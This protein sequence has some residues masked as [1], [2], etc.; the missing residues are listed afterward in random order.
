MYLIDTNVISEARKGK[1]ANP[2]VVAFFQQCLAQEHRIYLSV[3]TVGELRRGVDSQHPCRVIVAM[4]HKRSAWK[5][6]C[7]KSSRGIG[8]SSCHSIWTLPRSGVAC[9]CHRPSTLWT[10]RSPQPH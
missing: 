2:G 10:N 7:R 1:T 9:A 8:I 4:G 5:P 6:G 3:V